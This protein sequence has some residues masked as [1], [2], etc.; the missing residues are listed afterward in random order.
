MPA[1]FVLPDPAD[2][3]GA[4]S[5]VASNGEFWQRLVM[6]SFAVQLEGFFPHH[7]RILV[8]SARVMTMSPRLGTIDNGG[9]VIAAGKDGCPVVQEVGRADELT[10][11]YD[12]PVID[13]KNA[14]LIPGL[15]N[16]HS[17]LELSHLA[18]RTRS[19]Q[20][21]TA[22]A[23]SLHPLMR[24]PADRKTITG[25]LARM[26]NAGTVLAADMGGHDAP[27]VAGILEDVPLV[28]VFFMIQR[29]GFAR[30]KGGTLRPYAF[31]GPL[32]ERYLPGR[33]FAYSGHAL[34][35]THPQTLQLA[36]AW[37]DD[38]NLPFAIHLAESRDEVGLLRDGTGPL[39]ATLRSSNL[40]PPWFVPTGKTPVAYAHDL[41][42]LGPHTLAVHCVH[43]DEE[44]IA[45]LAS[46][47][48][49]VCL[50]PCS[51]AYIG[52]G[53]APVR[54]MHG[55]GINLCLGT[56]G[57][58]SN[59]ELDLSREMQAVRALDPGMDLEGVVRM[60]TR[61][62]ATILGVGGGQGTI[63]PGKKGC[64]AMVG[65]GEQ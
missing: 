12:L 47:G 16:C 23:E 50:C 18:G 53:S 30:P 32:I 22:W 61:N 54:A 8:R 37:C 36:K 42:L 7:N 59:E 38:H 2:R 27:V 1:F 43:V 55:A 58:S 60:A 51:N 34:Y 17:H 15:I 3:D 24:D 46:T 33:R 6:Q 64:L 31:A 65:V 10:D 13:C 28:D 29:M 57:L 49:S 48:T 45:L 9:V 26:R 20:G 35:S 25:V 19:G 21:F 62:A 52:V 40:L 56:D 5:G 63:E 41:G 14:P 39:A 44:D 4:I 11:R